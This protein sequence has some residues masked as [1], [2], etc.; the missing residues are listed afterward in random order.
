[1]RPPVMPMPALIR[2]CGAELSRQTESVISLLYQHRP[3][4]GADITT[5]ESADNL[6]AMQEAKAELQ[7]TLCHLWGDIC[8][9]AHQ[10]I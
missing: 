5:V 7:I 9:K 1:M 8:N 2:E 3:A 4:A 6:R 10:H